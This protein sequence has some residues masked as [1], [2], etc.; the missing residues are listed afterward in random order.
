MRLRDVPLALLM[1]AAA[2]CGAVSAP[3]YPA[4]WAP[5]QATGPGCDALAGSYANAGAAGGE[6]GPRSMH[7][8][9][10][11]FG[12]SPAIDRVELSAHGGALWATAWNGQTHVKAE[13]LTAAR[14]SRTEPWQVA[15]RE[16]RLTLSASTG[17]GETK[18]PAAAGGSFGMELA[19]AGDGALVVRQFERSGGVILFV[20]PTVFYLDEWYRFPPAPAP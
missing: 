2:G 15:C 4:A 1:L 18:V 5:I 9:T 13:P 7:L 17:S 20:I 10:R 12:E 8:W 16:G 14:R 11:L 6:Q 3:K 19:K